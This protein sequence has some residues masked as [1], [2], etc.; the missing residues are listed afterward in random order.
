[1]PHLTVA[2]AKAFLCI[3]LPP[4]FSAQAERN[5]CSF[6]IPKDAGKAGDTIG[7]LGVVIDPLFLH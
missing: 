3:R 5:I 1:M 4:T 2:V 7:R 6:L